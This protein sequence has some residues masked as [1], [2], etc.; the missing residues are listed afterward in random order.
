LVEIRAALFDLHRTSA[1][2]ENPIGEDEIPEYLFSKGYEISRQQLNAAWTFVAFVDYPKYGYKNW[3]SYFSRILQ[4]LEVR[5]DKETLDDVIR[6][7]EQRYLYQLYPDAAESVIKSKKC[8]LKTA[9]VTNIAYF[10]F[11]KAVEPVKKYTDFVMTG[12][13]AKCDKG[14]SKMYRKVL[15]ILKVRPDEAVMIGDDIELDILLQKRLGMCA[16]LLDR[17]RQNLKYQGADAVANSL[18]EALKIALRLGK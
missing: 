10:Q 9:I 16:I 11:K 8:G 17:K 13:E 3:R 6:L 14:N 1:Y 2:L 18:S 5:L 7:L 15:E 12:F 4:R